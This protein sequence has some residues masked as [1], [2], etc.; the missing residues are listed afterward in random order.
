LGLYTGEPGARE[1]RRILSHT[2][3]A[4]GANAQ[5]LRAAGR[6]FVA[7]SAR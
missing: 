6:S 4:P 1:F 5:L 3:H 7:P 2:A